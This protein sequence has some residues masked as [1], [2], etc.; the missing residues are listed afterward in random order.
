MSETIRQNRLLLTA[1]VLIMALIGGCNDSQKGTS[2]QPVTEKGGSVMAISLHSTAF[3]DKQ[4]IP[5]KYTGDGEDKSPPLNWTGLPDGTRE[6]ALI[7][8]DPDAP[9]P[10]PWVH[11]LLYKIPAAVD[12]LPEGV[13]PSM[14]VSTPA[15]ALQGKNSWNKIGYGGPAPPPGHGVHRYFFKLYA[16]DKPLDLKG[17][18]DKDALLAAMQGHILGQAELIGTYQ[19]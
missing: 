1:G 5:R 11:W 9:R 15:G 4:P 7:V 17:G 14:N 13:T 8:D 18:V 16:L 2:S 10:Q 6:L 3:G 19:R 12:R